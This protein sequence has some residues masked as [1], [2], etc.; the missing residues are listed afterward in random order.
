MITIKNAAQLD[1]MRA[2]G[3]LLHSV[4]TRVRG[5][6]RPGE[7]TS[8]VDAFAEELIRRA[9][10]VPSFLHYRGYPATICASIDDEVVHGIPSDRRVL[11]EGSILSVDCGLVLDGWQADSA[12]TVGVGEISPEKRRLIEVTEQCFFVGARM[13]RAGNRV[14]DIGQA[15]QQLAESNGYGVVRDLT[16]HGIGR[17][18]H[19]DPTVPNFGEAGQGAR[20]RA[21]MTLAL[22]PMIAMGGW[23]VQVDGD[24]WTVRTRDGSACAHHEHTIAVREDGLP[25][26]L[27]LPD[28][29]WE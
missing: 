23:Q 8:A 29:S 9:G 13:A 10:A 14:G 22:E 16:G 28:F 21:G 18:M 11:R 2:A 26:I 4:L 12:F 6:I 20:L 5:A 7:T 25:E 15:V 17:S 24:G 27:T 1:K 3:R 19:E